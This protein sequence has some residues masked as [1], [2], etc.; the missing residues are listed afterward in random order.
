[1][2]KTTRTI[3]SIFLLLMVF[4]SVSLFVAADGGTPV[5]V[6]N[7]D[8][9]Q[10]QLQ[11]N[12]QYEFQFRQRTRLRINASV[13]IDMDISCD[14]L[15]IGDKTFELEIEAENDL[16]MHMVCKRDMDQLGLMDGY[17]YQIRNRHQHRY[18]EKFAVSMEVNGTFIKARLRIQATNQNR[19]GTWAYYDEVSEE[20]V[21]V[22]THLRDG[23][24]ETETDHFS[25]WTIL[26]PDTTMISVGIVISG[27]IGAVAIVGLIVYYKRKR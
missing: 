10:G 2:R 14:A 27:I 8:T 24:L 26:V 18:I 23:Y 25:T 4:S 12:M 9:Y 7:A 3:F 13:N 20:W 16:T 6:P 21:P 5:E 22:Q 15:A 19:D 1:M 11:A 17:T